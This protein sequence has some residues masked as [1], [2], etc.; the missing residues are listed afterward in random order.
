MHCGQKLKHIISGD[1]PG[2]IMMV[3]VM[4]MKISFCHRKFPARNPCSYQALPDNEHAP[5]GSAHEK[6]ESGLEVV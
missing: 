3:M 1:T 5:K 2:L 6:N 4:M